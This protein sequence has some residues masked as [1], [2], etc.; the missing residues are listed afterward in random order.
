MKVVFRATVLT[1]LLGV[2]ALSQTRT[3]EDGSYHQPETSNSGTGTATLNRGTVGL[4]GIL[5]GLR[6]PICST[7]DNFTVVRFSVLSSSDC[8]G[9]PD[10]SA[11]FQ[12]FRPLSYTIP[13]S[14]PD[15]FPIKVGPLRYTFWSRVSQSDKPTGGRLQN[16][17]DGILRH[18]T[19]DP[20]V[21][22]NKRCLRALSCNSLY[23]QALRRRAV[24]TQ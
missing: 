17:V 7:Y 6:P 22:A 12:M 10:A 13:T 21:P 24:R 1:A 11:A 3:L 14:H 8:H 9:A 15:Y 18:Y 2:G 4:T 19:S 5:H 16:L 23:E 20:V